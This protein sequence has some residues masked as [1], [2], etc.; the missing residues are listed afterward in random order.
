MRQ[1]SRFG[2]RLLVVAIACLVAGSATAAVSLQA[3]RAVYELKLLNSRQGGNIGDITGRLVMEWG[4]D[5][6]GYVL[7]QRM[8]T[9]V[10]DLGGD[11]TLNDFQ[12]TSWESIDGLVFRFSSRD[13]LGD[14]VTEEIVGKAKLAGHGETGSVAFTKPQQTEVT[15]PAGTVFPSEQ[16]LLLLQAAEKGEKTRNILLFD[17]SRIDGLYDTFSVIGNE[18]AAADAT[19]L[20]KFKLLAGQKSWPVHVAYFS[21]EPDAEQPPETPTFQVG[22]RLYQNGIATELVLDYGEFALGGEL[23]L[24]EALPQPH[25]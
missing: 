17:G 5:C 15:L 6:Q 25:C 9:E 12:V 1:A 18:R 20:G 2:W 23:S 4:V 21:R 7:N 24:L 11:S 19:V 10:T 13:S 3:H 22:Y 16:S 14:K 8:L